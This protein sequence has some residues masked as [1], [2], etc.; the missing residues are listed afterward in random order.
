MNTLLNKIGYNLI[1]YE[2]GHGILIIDRGLTAISL[3]WR[4][5]LRITREGKV[6]VV[7]Q[8]GD[9]FAKIPESQD[10]R[11]YIVIPTLNQ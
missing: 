5:G 11:K 8:C 7:D 3:S 6:L 10:H 4:S 1:R 9:V 2:A